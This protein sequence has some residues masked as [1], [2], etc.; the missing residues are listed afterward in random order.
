MNARGCTFVHPGAMAVHFK[1]SI[2]AWVF[3][4]SLFM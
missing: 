1:N 2:L 4:F 3:K